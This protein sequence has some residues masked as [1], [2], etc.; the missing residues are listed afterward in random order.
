MH[1]AVETVPDIDIFC[2]IC[3]QTV[4]PGIRHPCSKTATIENLKKLLASQGL[5]TAEQ[6]IS[7]SLKEMKETQ[8]SNTVKI[9][10]GG[11][12]LIV[13]LWKL[14]QQKQISSDTLFNIK[15]YLDLPE[16]SMDNIQKHL[17]KD[18]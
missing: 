10:T 2:S 1:T 11:P 13:S 16:S 15:R 14:D 9:S 12:K 6:V 7:R 3:F 17:R 5:K 18:V 4:G 8:S